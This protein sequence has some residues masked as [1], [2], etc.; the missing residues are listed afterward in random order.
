MSSRIVE[1]ASIT[2]HM[3]DGTTSTVTLEHIAEFR[4]R[5]RLRR[6]SVIGGMPALIEYVIC[7]RTPSPPP[8]PESKIGIKQ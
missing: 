7:G 5:F 2:L 4:Q 8:E 6:P 1:K 3:S